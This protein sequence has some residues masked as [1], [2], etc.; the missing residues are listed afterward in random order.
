MACASC[1]KGYLLGRARRP[2]RNGRRATLVV[3][4]IEVVALARE[5]GPV[6]EKRGVDRIV[7]N[8]RC[9]RNW[10]VSRTQCTWAGH[11]DMRRAGGYKGEK[12]CELHD[13]D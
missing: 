7:D 8:V 13:E 3:E 6:W 12:E 10:V 1:S 4:D 2:V 11:V 9:F 5:V